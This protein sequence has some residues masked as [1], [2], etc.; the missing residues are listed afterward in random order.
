MSCFNSSNIY[1]KVLLSFL[2]RYR[3]VAYTA[4]IEGLLLPLC[5]YLSVIVGNLQVNIQLYRSSTM[6]S[7][8][9]DVFYMTANQSC[10]LLIIVMIQNMKLK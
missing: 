3:Y 6:N 7:L 2:R 9:R 5:G 10:M 4:K 8:R 1:L